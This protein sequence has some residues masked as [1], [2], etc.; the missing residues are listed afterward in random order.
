M[1]NVMDRELAQDR[2]FAKVLPDQKKMKDIYTMKITLVKNVQP[3]AQTTIMP[4]EIIVAMVTEPALI[5]V[6]AKI[7]QDENCNDFL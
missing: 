6:G 4:T 2:V 7:P 3:A 5:G 1:I